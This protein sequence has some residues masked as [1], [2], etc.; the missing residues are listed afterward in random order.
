[1]LHWYGLRVQ[2]KHLVAEVLVLQNWTKYSKQP[3]L[4]PLKLVA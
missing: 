1:M 3:P 4:Q 2:G